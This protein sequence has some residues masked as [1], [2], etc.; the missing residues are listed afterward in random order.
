MFS[1][2]QSAITVAVLASLALPALPAHA[3]STPTPADD[4]L[5]WHGITLYGLIDVGVA[6]QSHG[7][8][9]SD[10]FAQGVAY[11]V[12]KN[13]GNSYTGLAPNGLSQT[14]L[15]LKGEHAFTP[16]WSA[17]FDVETRFSPL[18]GEIA[19]GP[20][21]LLQN[22]GTP[23]AA[24]SANGDSS[25]A[26]QLFSAAA[27]AGI[28]SA[29]FGTL[30]FGR[31]D[32]LL[33]DNILTYDPQGG[34]YAFS[35]IGFSAVAAGGGDSEYNRLNDSVR[36]QNQF[37][38]VRVGA[39][40]QAAGDEVGGQGYQFNLGGDYAGVSVDLT[41]FNKKDAISLASYSPT[42]PQLTALTSA[43]LSLNNSLAATISD[44]HTIALMAK[45]SAAS[46]KLYGGFEAVTY[47]APDLGSPYT[48]IG[49]GTVGGYFIATANTS[50]YAHAKELDIVWAGAKVPVTENVDITGAVYHYNQNSYATGKTAGCSTTV[51]ASCSG[52]ETAWSLVADYHFDSHFDFYAGVF[53]TRVSGGL[54]AGFLN[55]SVLSGMTGVR[56]VF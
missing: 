21:S 34:S 20:R 50:A 37:G 45:Y 29:R 41:Y 51:S 56:L 15:G 2:R 39:Q 1:P 14:R 52:D 38:P 13:S 35:L 9:A 28:K 8:S 46:V 43:G 5:T 47:S 24:Q 16:E 40:Y 31:Q 49:A 42:A 30:T 23:L 32:G 44:N 6:Y 55:T 27:F 11:G 10:Y 18:S 19:N 4:A 53:D 26:G 3:D 48:A 36:Y 54:A 17:V 7:A 33:Y 22:N 25:Q 12:S